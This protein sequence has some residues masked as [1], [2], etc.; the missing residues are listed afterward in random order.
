MTTWRMPI[1][2][3]EQER[4]WLAWPTSGYT[5]GETEA[6]VEEARS[7]WAAVAN[8]ASEHEAVTVVVNPGDEAVAARYLSGQIDRLIAPLDDAWMRDIGPSFVIGDDGRLGAVNYVFNG[9]GAQ[10]WAS[11]EHDQHIGR[12]VAE[13]AGA[14]RIDSEMV[15]E[16]GGIQVDGTGRVIITRTVQL[17]PGRNPG[18]TEAQVEAELLRTIGADSALWL[19]RGLTR[20]HDTFGTR[21]HSDILAA[22]T[23]PDTLLMHRQDAASHPDHPI[24]RANRAAAEEYR[25]A[26][27]GSFEILDLPAPEALRDAEGYVDYSYINHVVINGAVLACAFDDPADDRALATLREV[28]PGREVIGIDARPLFARGGGI[29]CITQQQPKVS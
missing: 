10:D 8:A 23:T 2:G 28:Y 3:H 25:S 18:W 21:G 7:T 29:H 24:A 12:I 13:A 22:F 15:N 14:E 26:T 17:D 4:L 20:D 16:G 6:E 9:W 5:L 11:W 27:S 19:P 1:E